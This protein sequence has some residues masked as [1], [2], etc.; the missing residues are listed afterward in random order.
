MAVAMGVCGSGKHVAAG[1]R[2]SG[3]MWKREHVAAGACGSGKHVAAGTHGSGKHV[4][5]GA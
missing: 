3:S 5:M 1:A 4:A 2:G